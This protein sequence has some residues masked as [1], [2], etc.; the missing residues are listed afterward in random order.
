MRYIAAIGFAFLTIGLYAQTNEID[1]I[2]SNTHGLTRGT[3]LFFEVEGYEIFTYDYDDLYFD[4]TGIKIAKR[5]Y[6]IDKENSGEIDSILNVK[7]QYFVTDYKISDDLNQKSV[8]YFVPRE[9]NKLKVIA[10]SR[11]PDRDIQIERL[12]VES[13]IDNSL[14]D[15]VYSQS[16]TD[17]V[18]FAG[19]YLYLGG[20]CRWMGPHNVQCPDFGQISWSE[21]RSLERAK[22]SADINYQISANKKLGIVLEKDSVDVIF[23]GVETKALKIKYKIKIPQLIIGGSNILIVYY[24]SAEIRGNNVACVMSQYT[25][26]VNANEL[27]PLLGEVMKLNQ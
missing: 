23:E 1:N 2:F 26:D 4:K 9:D 10:F 3:S 13:I 21:F 15:Y 18:N 5:K 16:N 7:H 27:A 8:F 24:V 6:K 17:S 12:F 25:D 20:A 22:Q 11:A 14:P 19:R